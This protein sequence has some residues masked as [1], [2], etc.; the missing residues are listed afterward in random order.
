M[1]A[2]AGTQ[3]ITLT[4]GT[5]PPMTEGNLGTCTI[6][7]P[8]TTPA[9]APDITYTNKIDKNTLI[10]D[11]GVSNPNDVV[12]NITIKRWLTGTKSF[13]PAYIAQG[14]TSTVTITLKNNRTDVALSEIAFTDTM[15]GGLTVSEA[16]STSQCGGTIAST[17]SSVS[18]TDGTIA[19]NSTCTITF[20]VTASNTGNYSN[21][22]PVDDITTGEGAKNTEIKSN[23][24]LGVI[25]PNTPIKI[26]KDFSP[27]PIAPGTNAKLHIRLTAPLDTAVSGISFTDSLPAGMRITNSTPAS[28]G[29]GGTL[30]ADTGAS[31]I[32]LSGG[33]IANAGGTCDINVYVTVDASG[34]YT[35]TIGVN[36]VTTTEG[37]KNDTAASATLN[38]S[39]FSMRKQFYPSG[40]NPNGYSTL[41]ISLENSSLEAITDVTLLDDLATMGGTSPSEGVYVVPLNDHE[42]YLTTCGGVVVFP[43]G[44]DDTLGANERKIRL[45]GGTIPARVGEINGLCTITVAVQG[46]GP[47]TTRTN[48]INKTEATGKNSGITIQ[49]RDNATATLSIGALSLRV[50]KGFDPLLV[51]GGTDSKLS[52]QL[53]NPNSVP[54]TGVAFVDTMPAGMIVANPANPEVGTCG[55]TL[56]AIPGEGKFTFT[57]GILEPASS[58]TLTLR[59]TMTVTGNRTNP[60]PAQAVSTY[61]GVKNPDPTEATLTNLP[62]A[63]ISKGFG[64]EE[65][66][67]GPETYSLLTITIK[68]INDVSLTNLG[69]IDNLPGT[70]PAGLMIAAAPPSVNNCGGTLTAVPGTQKIELS[71]GTLATYSS[72][73]IIVPVTGTTAG[74][75]TNV[76]PDGNLTD[77]EDV[78]NTTPTEDTLKIKDAL[79]EI[80]VTKTG[81]PVNIPEEGGPVTFTYTVTNKTAEAVEITA[82]T[83]DKF[84]I[85]GDDDC[86]VGTILAGR[87]SCSFE[88]TFTIP[89]GTYPGN[90][91]NVFMATAEDNEGNTDSAQDNETVN[92]LPNGSIVIDKKTVPSGDQTSFEF[93]TTGEGYDAF[94]LADESLPN[95]QSLTPNTT[96]S[97]VETVPDGWDLTSVV[98]ESSIG[99]VETAAAIE[100][101][102]GEVVTCTF[103]DTKRGIIQIDKNTIPSD[104]QDVFDFDASWSDELIRLSNAS[105]I[106]ESGWLLPGTYQISENVPNGWDLTSANCES[107]IGDT[108]TPNAIELDPGEVVTCTFTDTKRASLTLKKEVVNDN[109]GTMEAVDFQASITADGAEDPENVAWD[110]EQLLVPGIYT[111]RESELKGYASEGWQCENTNIPQEPTVYGLRSLN[112]EITLAPG[113]EAVC[114]ITNDD[115]S[116]SL[117]LNKIVENPFRG[118]EAEAF[119]ELKADG[120]EAGVLSGPGA[121]GEEDVVSDET[122][123][124]GTYHLSEK[125]LRYINS[126]PGTWSC[127][128]NDGDAVE[129]DVVQIEVGDRVICSI[130][131]TLMVKIPMTGFSAKRLTAIRE[132]PSAMKYGTLGIQ[133]EVPI[134]DVTTEVVKVPE[135]EGSWAVE[136]LGSRAGL[137]SGSALPGEGTSYVAA[138]NHLNNMEVGPFLFIKDLAQNDRIFVRNNE[139]KLLEFSVYANELFG[140]DD[141]NLVRQ[142][143]EEFENTLVLITCENEA[144]DGGYL[145]RRIVFAKR[146]E[147]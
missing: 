38:A 125:R 51:Y 34:S 90:H 35:N 118:I 54:L 79:P 70:L 81:D 43:D 113:D 61:N 127:V 1:T 31:S 50:V 53:I 109:G 134:L 103:T 80:E 143:A 72:C 144:E 58:C 26:A 84:T 82:L 29:C 142:K 93:T 136:W 135:E 52:V 104:S 20:K 37:R 117:V 16:P 12:A 114:T 76:I 126:V 78:T 42:N 56:T 120:G 77:E 106:G 66:D 140:P 59:I 88:H 47:L 13:S 25:V 57:G 71:G 32:S 89:A 129:G 5:I 49:P 15:P 73:T 100:L 14:G 27:N 8:V 62:G 107:S 69:M 123:Q 74:T 122:F 6:S 60:I 85:I 115:I 145:N 133:I 10:T 22:I 4:D 130:T 17:L 105:E 94:E 112:N 23:P 98:C 46:K 146:S 40:V 124:A 75:Y 9:N 92:R 87:S 3:A 7:V 141:F 147:E 132:Q 24:N 110:E 48:T 97:V 30:T 39:S 83:D 65:I 68:N 95:S 119:W 116:P 67:E 86:K 18:L 91:V 101:D 63:S 21:T 138:H 55:G 108:E 28:N 33:A 36:A 131:N 137:L 139:G 11:Q 45:T 2:T 64:D 19:A 99:D 41:T 128:K 111:L 121:T 44:S 102:P 96:Y